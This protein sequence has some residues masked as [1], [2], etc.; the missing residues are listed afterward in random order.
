KPNKKAAEPPM[1]PDKPPPITDATILQLY[2]VAG[3]RCSFPGCSTYLFEEPLTKRKARLGN[4]AHIVG[5]S[6]DGPRGNDP[7]PM[8]QRSE[9]ENIMLLCSKCH[10][11]VDKKEL[12]HEYPAW[13]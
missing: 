11:F 12:E 13:L 8:A 1:K 2:V 4:I 5:E 10:L 9:V 3:G 7:L 6:E